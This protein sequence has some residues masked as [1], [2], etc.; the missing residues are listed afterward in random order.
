[1]FV[2]NNINC[3]RVLINMASVTLTI[4]YIRQY[5]YLNYR[6]YTLSVKS[7]YSKVTYTII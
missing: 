5:A 1:M 4:I 7:N 2:L 3:V 6:N